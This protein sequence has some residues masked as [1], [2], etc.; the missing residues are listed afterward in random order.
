MQNENSDNVLFQW[1]SIFSHTFYLHLLQKNPLGCNLNP[2]WYACDYVR[3][4]IQYRNETRERV[5]LS[6]LHLLWL[7]S[8]KLCNH[9][10]DSQQSF[11]IWFRFCLELDWNT[12]GYSIL[13]YYFNFSS[14]SVT[15]RKE[16]SIQ[17]AISLNKLPMVSFYS[18]SIAHS[19]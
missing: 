5:T 13:V 12:R 11:L 10:P 16:T 18:I 1:N 19:I 4:I 8:K 2:P 6:K 7:L 3:Y 17:N 14:I 9:Y 15:Y